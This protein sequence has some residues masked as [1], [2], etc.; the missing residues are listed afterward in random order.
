MITAFGDIDTAVKALKSGASDFVL[1]P[2][3]MR[4]YLPL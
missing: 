4:N 1:N 3:T 2:G